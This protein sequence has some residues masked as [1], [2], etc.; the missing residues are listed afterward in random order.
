MPQ[1]KKK[2][3]FKLHPTKNKHMQRRRFLKASSLLPLLTGSV[4]TLP[5]MLSAQEKS[6]APIA[7]LEG[8]GF[9]YKPKGAW[10]GDFIPFYADGTFQLFYLLSFRNDK[11]NGEGT[12]WYRLTTNNFVD[13]KEYGE[14]IPRGSKREQD[15]YI[16]TGSAI[17]AKGKYHIFYTGHN[18]HLRAK[19]KPE[20]AIM[21]AVSDDLQNW[22]KI[23]ED[24]FFA[25]KDKYEMH[26]WRDPFVFWD[27]NDKVYYML[28]AA[29]STK[30]I[31][32][33]R[34]LTALCS[35]IDL[36]TW[37]VEENFYKP[38]L[39]FTHECPDLFKIGEWWYLVFSEFTDKV[40]TRYVKS[41]S[42]KGPWVIPERDD[43]DGHAFYA[44]KSASDGNRR[45]LFGWNPTREK[46]KDTGDWQWGGNLVVHEI[47]QEKGG[48]LK[49]IM[50]K[51]VGQAFTQKKQLSFTTGSGKFSAT[52][53]NLSLNATNTFAC[54]NAGKLPPLCRIRAV[55]N[56][57]EQT[58]NFGIMFHTSDDFDQ[59]YY[60]TCEPKNQQ[61]IFD[62]WPREQS[63]VTQLVELERPL[64]MKPGEPVIIDAIIEGTKG[65]VYINNIVAM[66]FRCY[67]FKDGNWG[68]FATNGE[69]VFS[70]MDIS[71]R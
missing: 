57:D 5:N 8:P 18:P 44:A 17:E 65:V 36:K 56:F 2:A 23:P 58:S 69:V 11:E 39:Y 14:V 15:L 10:A 32:R 60:I 61:L 41:N 4:L 38:D 12:P 46:E 24:T 43:F 3:L 54:A 53:N 42:V 30:G 28:L 20:Q 34:G 13:F 59:S 25:P 68:F 66:N 48:D 52:N 37:K 40:R 33:R 9:F 21:H 67:D 64:K 45:F 27:E 71:I 35:S 26:D 6:I 62:K 50:P 55:A 19:G 70:F 63:P 49:V 47:L 22:A 51:E 29:R 31:P 1:I 7:D 16:F